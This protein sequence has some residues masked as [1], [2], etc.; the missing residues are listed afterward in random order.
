VR[1][2]RRVHPRQPGSSAFSR[3]SPD[4]LASAPLRG[5]QHLAAEDSQRDPRAVAAATNTDTEPRPVDRNSDRR[6]AVAGRIPVRTESARIVTAG[7]IPVRHGHERETV[8]RP[9]TMPSLYRTPDPT[10]PR[11]P[12][13]A[14]TVRIPSLNGSIARIDENG[15]N[16]WCGVHVPTHPAVSG[17]GIPRSNR[18]LQHDHRHSNSHHSKSHG[19]APCRL[20]RVSDNRQPA[21]EEPDAGLP[22]TGGEMHTAC[23][24]GVP[25]HAEFFRSGNPSQHNNLPFL[26]HGKTPDRR[27][28]S[29]RGEST[30]VSQTR[31]RTWSD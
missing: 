30:A 1:P 17:L 14:E 29:A 7:G 5:Q 6:T 23:Q 16:A 15:G 2:V 31:V 4:D 3:T 10:G 9:R 13:A 25:Q 18:N 20:D 22:S 8:H 19:S 12:V 24:N 28:I 26:A 11:E 27:E 21:G